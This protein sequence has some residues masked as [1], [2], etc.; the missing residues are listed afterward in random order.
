MTETVDT[1]LDL[2][3]E[4]R[5]ILAA[6]NNMEATLLI[7]GPTGTGKSHLARRM[8]CAS[9]LRRGARFHKINLATLSESLLES[10]LF[11]HER[12]SFT[13]A[14]HKRIGRIEACAGGTLFLDEVGELPPRLQAK[15]LDFIQYKR[16]VPIGSN[17]ELEV[18]VRIIAA[19]NRDLAKAVERREFRADLFHRLKVFHVELAPL[20]GDVAR[21]Q[22][23]ARSFLARACLRQHRAVLRLDPAAER[24]LLSYSWPGNIRELENAMEYACGVETGAYVRAECLPRTLREYTACHPQ[25]FEEE[26]MKEEEKEMQAPPIG[27]LE[28]PI[29][30]S[31]HASKA[32]FERLYLEHVLRLCE[33]QIN[34]TS[35]RTGLNK[36]SLS[37]KIRRHSINWKGFRTVG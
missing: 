29:H 9:L 16:I 19:T 34:L 20:K 7:T 3:L 13:G 30:M 1:F 25:I 5:T 18:D 11:G 14:D 27:T 2:S 33:G 36:V 6:S 24:I 35:R 37:G 22:S 8:H 23:L 10:E 15:L 26:N 12:G 4:D 21:I 31:Y 28:L 32:S 17:R